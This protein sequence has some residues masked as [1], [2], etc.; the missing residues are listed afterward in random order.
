MRYATDGERIHGFGS[1]EDRASWLAEGQNRRSIPGTSRE[2]KKAIYENR[3]V[4]VE[5]VASEGQFN[6]RE[7]E[8]PRSV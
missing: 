1:A 8:I 2:V 4:F 6:K 7:K 5:A 3:V